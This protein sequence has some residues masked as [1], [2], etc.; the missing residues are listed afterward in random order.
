M[1]LQM[2]FCPSFSWLSG[3]PLCTHTPHP[4]SCSQRPLPAAVNGAAANARLHTSFPIT[5]S[6]ELY[7]Q[8]SFKE[9][10]HYSP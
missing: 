1:S 4:L 3:V 7:F 8:F 10:L 5:V 6:W 2:A 9:P